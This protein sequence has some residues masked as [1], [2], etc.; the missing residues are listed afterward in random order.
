MRRI[1]QSS[2][3]YS[4]RSRGRFGLIAPSTSLTLDLVAT[5]P[6]A[7]Y[8]MRR[9]RA[10]YSG[11]CIRIRRSSDNAEQDIGFVGNAL[12]TAAI[13]SFIG[14]GSGFIVRWYDQTTNLNHLL[15]TTAASQPTY[16]SSLMT[17]DGVND[18]MLFTTAI[19]QTNGYCIF[20]NLQA[21]DT[22][23]TKGVVSG[24]NVNGAL[25][26]RIGT[27]EGYVI[28]RQGQAI[29]ATGATTGRT[30][31]TVTRWRAFNAGCSIHVNG[32]SDVS[33]A[34][35]AALTQPLLMIG[36][37]ATVGADWFGGNMQEMLIYAA[38]LSNADSNLIGANMATFAGTSWTNI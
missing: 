33:N 16:G 25:Y 1:R 6:V 7:A 15:Q 2:G 28:T 11:S 9:L 27:T 14:G 32:V 18:H 12:D 4:V 17:F 30:A 10:A 8:G 29:L 35:N 31:K 24:N 23:L 36:N 13:S 22:A 26:I 38:D 3:G 21:N 34:T 37:A 5:Q 19:S 20:T